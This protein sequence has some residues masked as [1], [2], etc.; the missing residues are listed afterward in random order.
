MEVEDIGGF[1]VENEADGPL[2]CFF[3]LPHFARDVVAVAELIREPL[4]GAV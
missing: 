4:A 2:L 3:L 1:G